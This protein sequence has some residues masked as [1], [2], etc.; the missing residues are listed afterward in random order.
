LRVFLKGRFVRYLNALAERREEAECTVDICKS[1]EIPDSD[2]D[3]EEESDPETDDE[4]EVES[5]DEDDQETAKAVGL[6]D[7]DGE[8]DDSKEVKKEPKKESAKSEGK[9]KD[10]GSD[11]KEKKKGEEEKTKI[12]RGSWVCWDD[13][14]ALSATQSTWAP[15]ILHYSVCQNLQG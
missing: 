13:R 3:V 11:G 6:Q 4:K 9:T 8:D 1:T 15:L 14:T 5:K 12:K 2:S 7:S 10:S